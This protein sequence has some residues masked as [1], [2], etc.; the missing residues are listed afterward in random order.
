M[1]VRT[2]QA[3]V[4][5][6]NRRQ[7]VGLL[8]SLVAGLALSG[9]M[10]MR[11][12]VWAPPRYKRNPALT[13]QTLAAFVGTIVPGQPPERD[14]AAAEV[15]HDKYYPIEPY[16][17]FLASD[18]DRRAES[19]YGKSFRSLQPAQRAQV[20]ARALGGDGLTRQLYTGAIF[21]TQIAT[22]GGIENDRAGCGLIDFAGG[23][24]LPTRDEL[25]YADVERF[26]ATAL[27]TDGNP[28]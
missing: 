24:R 18:L 10:P 4:Y 14:A 20:V 21:L 12:V 6:P 27:T 16:R 26:R 17:A 7:A 25:T 22:F 23:Y 28:A 1:P 19:L 5:Q 11:I 15:F 13:D 8:A 2:N 9:C 3:N